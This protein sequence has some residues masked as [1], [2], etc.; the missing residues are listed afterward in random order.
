MVY[1]MVSTNV[2]AAGNEID[3]MVRGVDMVF[4]SSGTILA[5]G[6]ILTAMLKV[7]KK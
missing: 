3:A 2:A 1:T 6:L 7:E 5:F 4:F